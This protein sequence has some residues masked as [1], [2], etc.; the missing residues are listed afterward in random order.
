MA[1][2]SKAD[3]TAGLGLL[4]AVHG[5]PGACCVLWL[6]LAHLHAWG[7]LPDAVLHRCIAFRRSD[8]K[9]T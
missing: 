8:L 7:R 9:N 5:Q 6:S 4:I 2:E 1:G 3:V